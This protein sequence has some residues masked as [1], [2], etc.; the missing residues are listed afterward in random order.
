[1]IGKLV[2]KRWLAIETVVVLIGWIIFGIG[3]AIQSHIVLKLTLLAIARA[4]PAGSVF[5]RLRQRL[6]G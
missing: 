2:A 5:K 6:S 4:M 3:A 1:M